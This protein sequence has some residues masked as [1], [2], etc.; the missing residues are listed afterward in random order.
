MESSVMQAHKI[1]KRPII[2]EK[3]NYQA[4]MLRRYTFEVDLEANKPEIRQ[5]VEEMFDVEVDKVNT[6][7]MPGKPRRFGR[8]F[9]Y[10]SMWK[11]AVVTLA[12]GE[13]ISFFEG[14]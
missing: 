2:T 12:P 11:K 4:D 1:L 13:S 3:S 6:M 5:A 10:T 8:R 7:V 9:G 14:V